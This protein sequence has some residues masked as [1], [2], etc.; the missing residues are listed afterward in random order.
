M[1]DSSD[2]GSPTAPGPRSSSGGRGRPSFSSY[3]P[4]DPKV[5]FLVYVP[6]E[7]TCPDLRRA[8]DGHASAL[9]ADLGPG[10][11]RVW[12]R[13]SPNPG[14]T[15][16]GA[17]SSSSSS[18]SSTSSSTTSGSAPFHVPLSR[19]GYVA[20][21]E[22]SLLSSLLVRAI[23][24]CGIGPFRVRFDKPALFVNAARTTTYTVLLLRGGTA[25]KHYRG[26]TPA[27]GPSAAVESLVSVVDCALMNS[28]LS[29]PVYRY[30][31]PILPHMTFGELDGDIGDEL[32]G[33]YAVNW[34]GG[35]AHEF[36]DSRPA[37]SSATA[38]SATTASTARPAVPLCPPP[39]WYELLG[40]EGEG[41]ADPHYPFLTMPQFDM[42]PTPPYCRRGEAPFRAPVPTGAPGLTE[43]DVQDLI[44]AEEYVQSLRR[45]TALPPIEIREVIVR[46]G[47]KMTRVPLTAAATV[48]A[49][50]TPGGAGAGGAGA[51]A[52]GAGRE[53]EGTP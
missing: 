49:P 25:G 48:P 28:R 45:A 3:R 19:P 44:E 37:V 16:D 14:A 10:V 38:A 29:I 5:P 23:A 32:R 8:I 50:A 13:P 2:D 41:C 6:L 43:R 33:E 9:A 17:A 34:A 20:S 18:S 15:G 46:V 31:R 40:Q 42:A 26:G 36:W 12:S 27:R 22:A 7:D 4:S 53:E 51:G 24:T 35:K 39:R 21:A 47:N 30:H 52:A 1:S 11:V